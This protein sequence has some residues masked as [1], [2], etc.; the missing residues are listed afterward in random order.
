MSIRPFSSYDDSICRSPMAE[1]VLKHEIS[2]H[3][4]IQQKFDIYV[5]SAGTGAY[6]EGEE[7]DDR[8]IAVCKKHGIKADSIARAVIKEDFAKFNYIL[9]MDQSNLQTLLNRQPSSSTSQ[10]SL[11]GSFSPSIPSSQQGKSKTKAEAISDPYYG[12]RDGFEISYRKCGEFAKGFLE[13]LERE[14]A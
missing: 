9:A 13:Y 7:A 3:L 12:G 6:H 5:D 10:I 1:A 8:T 11:F 4:S 14:R 2:T